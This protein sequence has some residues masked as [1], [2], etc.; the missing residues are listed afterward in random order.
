MSDIVTSHGS[1]C[2]QFVMQVLL[3]CQPWWRR[4]KGN[5]LL[6]CS[7]PWISWFCFVFSW[8]AEDL[9]AALA[10]LGF[11]DCGS[12]L[13]CPVLP[14][15]AYYSSTTIMAF[16][17]CSWTCEGDYFPMEL[18]SVCLVVSRKRQHSSQMSIWLREG[19]CFSNWTSCLS[20]Q[21]AEWLQG[22]TGKNCWTQ[23]C[24]LRQISAG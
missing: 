19:K 24:H 1:T 20:H 18:L 23:G 8:W 16:L 11:P 15:N 6:Q 21:S 4:S 7:R 17:L 9:L 13:P 2:P 14:Q 22:Y 12:C 10:P 3:P 5:V